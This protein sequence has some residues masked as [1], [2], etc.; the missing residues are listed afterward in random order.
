M[1]AGEASRPNYKSGEF[2]FELDDYNASLL[3][4][5]KDYEGQK[6]DANSMYSFYKELTRI[7]G[8]YPKSAKIEYHVQTDDNCLI[9]K[10]TGI[11]KA[12]VIYI[13]CG[14]T[15]QNMPMKPH[16]IV[17]AEC[18][19]ISALNGAP[20]SINANIGDYPYG[21]SVWRAK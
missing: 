18:E 4:G 8:M 9:I 10:V 5:G 20:N 2:R 6:A 11:G 15:G 7:K 19:N 16:E 12:M 3:S 1:P 17:G 14:R 13:N 21:I